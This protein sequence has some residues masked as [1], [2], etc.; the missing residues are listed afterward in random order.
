[1]FDGVIFLRRSGGHA[2]LMWAVLRDKLLRQAIAVD[3]GGVAP[4]GEDQ[5][6]VGPQED[7]LR[8]PS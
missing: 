3:K 6:A 5:A 4:T 7:L 8:D 1:M 2:L